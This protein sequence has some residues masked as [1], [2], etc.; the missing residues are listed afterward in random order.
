M[1]R[2]LTLLPV[3]VAC[4]GGPEVPDP[5]HAEEARDA[6]VALAA[7]CSAV[8]AS[9]GSLWTAEHCIHNDAAP[10]YVTRDDQE[11][12]RSTTILWADPV[13]DV[14]ELGTLQAWE[15]VPPVRL[16]EIGEPAYVVHHMCAGA[17]CLDVGTIDAVS[18]SWSEGAIAIDYSQDTT[19]VRG[20]SGSGV[21]GHDGA[22]LGVLT[23]VGL[24]TGL[25]YFAL[26]GR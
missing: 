9:A 16:P 23:S 2:A 17:W 14:A 5:P 3:L 20:M 10:W 4:S 15:P 7:R 12:E 8:V 11:T 25:G 26:V 13:R 24:E 19:Q 22:L 6:T 21:W 1:L 18:A